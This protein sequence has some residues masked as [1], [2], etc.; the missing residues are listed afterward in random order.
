VVLHTGDFRFAPSV[1]ACLHA[2]LNGS[3]LDVLYLDT[4]YC[5]R[6]HAFPSQESVVR[7][8]ISRCQLLRESK[9]TL[10]LF[11]AYTI[12]K[13]RVFLEA[14]RQVGF[15][16]HVSAARLS[17]LACLEL[18]AEDMARFTTD[19]SATRCVI[20]R[21]NSRMGACETKERLTASRATS[22]T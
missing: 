12:G 11:G 5:H 4:T 13:E 19:A 6:R 20:A 10:V 9:R 14:A 16:L 18:S 7:S 15:R 22:H 8:V 3:P 17:T 21:V 2:A 1:G